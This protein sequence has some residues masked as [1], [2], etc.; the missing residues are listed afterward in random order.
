M[1]PL[2]I[3]NPQRMPQAYHVHLCLI[4]QGSSYSYF[5]G[6]FYPLGALPTCHRYKIH[7]D[8][9]ISPFNSHLVFG[10][11]PHMMLPIL[12]PMTEEAFCPRLVPYLLSSVVG[13]SGV[14]LRVAITILTPETS[15]VQSLHTRCAPSLKVWQ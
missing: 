15:Q 2:L 10:G 7:Q 14:S 1:S 13:H 5:C 4:V 12:F 6:T 9:P 11:L 3:T 8:Y